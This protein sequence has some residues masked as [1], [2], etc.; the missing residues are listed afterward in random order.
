MQMHQFLSFPP[1][2]RA[3]VIAR[4]TPYQNVKVDHFN[5][6]LES[7]DG[8][9]KLTFPRILKYYWKMGKPLPEI[10]QIEI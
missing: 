1:Q 4:E 7:S 10:L 2:F 5:R 8:T 3:L 6:R 9:L